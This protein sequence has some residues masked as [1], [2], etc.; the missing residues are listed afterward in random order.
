MEYNLP[1]PVSARR[2]FVNNVLLPPRSTRHLSGIKEAQKE[3][4]PMPESNREVPHGNL[5]LKTL[6]DPC[7]NG[8]KGDPDLDIIAV[9]GVLEQPEET[10][11]Y[12]AL[13]HSS[14]AL[15]PKGPSFAGLA[16]KEEHQRHILSVEG[17]KKFQ[18]GKKVRK[19]NWLTDRNMLSKAF[20][21]ARIMRFNYGWKH[22]AQTFN[23]R[24]QAAKRLLHELAQDRRN[25]LKYPARPILFIGHSFGGV[26]IQTA[27]VLADQE[28]ESN[29]VLNRNVDYDKW[30]WQRESRIEILNATVGVIFLATPFKITSSIR[31]R[32]HEIGVEVDGPKTSELP[33]MIRGQSPELDARGSGSG[34]TPDKFNLTFLKIAREEQYRLACFYEKPQNSSKLQP[35]AVL[36]DEN[37]STL[38]GY[39]KIPL[40]TNH[41]KM[42]KYSGQHDPSYTILVDAI[43]GFVA[44]AP[45]R[46]VWKAIDFGAIHSVQMMLDQ[47][48]DPNLQD[49]QGD[50]ALHKAVRSRE[51][52]PQLV[53]ALISRGADVHLKNINHKTALSVAEVEGKS[54]IAK[55]LRRHGAT[56][57][58]GDMK[59]AGQEYPLD[60][61]Y[62]DGPSHSSNVERKTDMESLDFNCISA[63]RQSTLSITHF[64][65]SDDGHLDRYRLKASIFDSLYDQNLSDE[66]LQNALA[67]YQE[68][69]QIKPQESLF[70]WYHLPANNM[71]WVE[72]LFTKL[73]KDWFEEDPNEALQSLR[74]LSGEQHKLNTS[75]FWNMRSDCRTVD[76]KFTSMENDKKLKALKEQ[77]IAL[78]LFM[79]YLHF[80][81][82]ATQAEM[83]RHMEISTNSY[84]L[85]TAFKHKPTDSTILFTTTLQSIADS[86]SSSSEH[87]SH[88]ESDRGTAPDRPETPKFEDFIAECLKDPPEP[89]LI[90]GYLNMEPPLHMRRSLDQFYSI[91]KQDEVIGDL[92]TDQIVYKYFEKK[93]L[94]RATM[95]IEGRDTGLVRGETL[96]SETTE[97]YPN[98]THA[99]KELMKNWEKKKNRNNPQDHPIVIVDQLWLWIVDKDTIVTS[100]PRGPKSS[101][102]GILERIEERLTVSEVKVVNDLAGLIIDECAGFLD[103]CRAP[104]NIPIL[105]I[106]DETISD[107]MKQQVELFDRFTETV[108]KSAVKEEYRN[109]RAV[110]KHGDMEQKLLNHDQYC[111]FLSPDFEQIPLSINEEA[112]L[113]REIRDA[114]EEL[115]IIKRILEQQDRVIDKGLKAMA[116]KKSTD[117]EAVQ[118]FNGGTK[119]TASPY[120]AVLLE[121]CRHN[122]V[123]NAD[124]INATI[125]SNLR[126]VKSMLERAD[127][128]CD[129]LKTLLDLKQKE[130]NAQEARATRQ[131][132]QSNEKQSKIIL[133]FTIVTIVFMP[134]SFLA[135]FFALNIDKFPRSTG[136]STEF[137]LTWVAGLICK[138]PED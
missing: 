70:T 17:S 77:K 52:A 4:Q 74:S 134:L 117:D 12:D 39:P 92:D 35:T 27:V 42:S 21:R 82:S 59:I 108:L 48:A 91:S 110:G 132:A 97:S 41:T 75:R 128:V 13:L 44:F 28:K 15:E 106:Y 66:I 111:S 116:S 133:I 88:L 49:I 89:Y 105:D 67:R 54:E 114:K 100:F 14:D 103:R 101:P 45:T 137:S 121:E 56:V 96:K 138:S 55:I 102:H 31:E 118:K 58:F 72:K 73:I 53:E 32:W 79:P 104:E 129:G 62:M 80:E 136:G 29:F 2:G 127:E 123:K 40:D 126:S 124:M 63:C 24:T 113:L 33:P 78:K 119:S 30:A 6:Y 122:H 135:S 130:V 109:L 64:C 87:E 84:D 71:A 61:I 47:G 37:S 60:K 36:L 26:V 10:W 9:H 8:F 107:A 99:L 46:Q 20:P 85:Q 19:L 90:G 95:R 68:E 5:G 1:L 43:K 38:P 93:R 11:T 18:R 112:E 22:G 3:Y 7:K 131:I 51:H 81:K 76:L 25:I 69:H 125:Q 23:I 65:P 115:N 83:R 120:P 50:S 86:S 34:K 57:Q 94:H 98:H 16:W